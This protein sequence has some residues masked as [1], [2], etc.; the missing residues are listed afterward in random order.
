M[1]YLIRHADAVSGPVDAKRQLSAHGHAQ[2]KALSLY[3]KKAQVLVPDEIWHS[4]LLR[5]KETASGLCDHLAWSVPLVET[6]D[7]R[8][9]D[10]P[11]IIARKIKKETKHIAVVGHNPYLEFLATVLTTGTPTP[12]VII[13]E[14]AS[15]IVLGKI[16]KNELGGWAM[17][18]HINA[19][20]LMR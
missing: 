9:E 2:V 17:I 8:P 15:F 13:M 4:S 10:D 12:E 6:E 14:K 16:R 19:D 5:A 18:S 1:L 11:L 3:L 7:L 20:L